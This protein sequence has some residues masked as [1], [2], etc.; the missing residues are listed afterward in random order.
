MSEKVLLLINPHLVA[1]VEP[2]GEGER[3]RVGEC[4]RGRVPEGESARRGGW[5]RPESCCR[6]I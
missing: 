1:W 5:E 2:E 4:Q 3:E 6:K